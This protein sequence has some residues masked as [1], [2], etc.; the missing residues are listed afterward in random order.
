MWNDHGPYT[1][2]CAMGRTWGGRIYRTKI[3]PGGAYRRKEAW[4]IGTR[5]YHVSVPKPRGGVSW[6]VQIGDT[7]WVWIKRR[8]RT[9]PDRGPHGTWIE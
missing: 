6:S 9:R 5:D 1:R 3:I 7:V 2:Y 8:Y 4:R